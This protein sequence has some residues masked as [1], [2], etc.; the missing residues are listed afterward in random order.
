MMFF[1]RG[2]A[3]VKGST[4]RDGLPRMRS[5]R[6]EGTDDPEDCRPRLR[7]RVA[8][9]HSGLHVTRYIHYLSWAT[10]YR[11]CGLP[12]ASKHLVVAVCQSFG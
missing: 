1:R 5:S 12:R 10:S 9:G 11:R 4:I 6:C 3:R 7:V 2:R 8:R